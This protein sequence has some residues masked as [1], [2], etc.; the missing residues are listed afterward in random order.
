[1]RTRGHVLLSILGVVAIVG[2]ASASVVVTSPSRPPLGTTNIAN[3]VN[4]E[5]RGVQVAW[6]RRQPTVEGIENP[7]VWKISEY[8]AAE[9][10]LPRKRFH[11]A[12]KFQT[13]DPKIAAADREANRVAQAAYKLCMNQW[14]DRCIAACA[15]EYP[16]SWH[17][18][19]ADPRR[20]ECRYDCDRAMIYH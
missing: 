13:L 4:H 12:A 14:R 3:S 6:K 20:L 1:M 10:A 18:P 17:N 8:R 11:A 9:C 15:K 2:A 7:K 16:K 5:I 19:G